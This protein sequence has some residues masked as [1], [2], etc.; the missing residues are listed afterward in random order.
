[1]NLWNVYLLSL[2]TICSLGFWLT[3]RWWHWATRLAACIALAIPLALP[4]TV[5]DT[6]ERAPAWV[7]AL[8]EFAFGSE[9]A[10]RAAALPLAAGVAV[11]LLSFG[12]FVFVRRDRKPA[13]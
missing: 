9:E 1:M 12:V 5:G 4:A 11:A 8:F 2:L 13:A 3:R 7:I 10:A 6:A